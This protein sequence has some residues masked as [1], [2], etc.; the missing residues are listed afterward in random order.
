M[1]CLLASMD[2]MTSA[3]FRSL[4]FE[5]GADGASTEMIGAVGLARAKGRRRPVM[6][7]LLLRRPEEGRLAAQIIG[8]DVEAMAAAAAKIEALGRFD[9]VEINMGCPARCVV[10]GGSGA[11][12]LR[13]PERAGEILRAVCGRVS[14]PVRL[15]LRL[16]WDA[17]HISAPE[18]AR[19]AQDAG[20]A[21][22]IL[23]GRN[24]SQGYAGEV[25]LEAM[26]CVR[27][28]ISIP[29]YA[30]GAVSCARDAEA[31]SKA[32]GAQGVC[33]GRAALKQPWIFEDI[34][35]IER[36]DAPRERD[37]RARVM[38]LLRFAGRLC[39]QKPERFAVQELRKYSL[40]YLDGLRGA[41][42]AFE[43]IK[44]AETLEDFRRIHLEYLNALERS[45][46]VCVHPE[47]RADASLNTV[48]R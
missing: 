9:L 25:D 8:R 21:E 15:K 36:G 42:E 41:R 11:A 16:G 18:I 1:E 43:H 6:E 39:A 34:R 23:H 30:N 47:L 10:G 5:Y 48:A 44:A 12:L 38:L 32:V 22:I 40:W 14:L 3:A 26:R 13:D 28:A 17:D 45:G 46:D 19:I 24:R 7:A 37:A 31:F 35:A 4:C 2:G 27:A 29:L 33:I 20:C